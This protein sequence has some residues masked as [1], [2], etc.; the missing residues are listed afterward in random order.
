MS[1]RTSQKVGKQWE[2]EIIEAYYKR[3]AQPI[4]LATEING[5]CFDI[6]QR[7]HLEQ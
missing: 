7:L 5:T 2:Q 6:A 3:G 1:G 4:K